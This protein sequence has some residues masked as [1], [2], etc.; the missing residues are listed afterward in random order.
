MRTLAL[1][2]FL[3]S[4]ASRVAAVCLLLL[5]ALPFTAPFS[6]CDLN[7]AL[8][9]TGLDEGSA[10]S[11]SNKIASDTALPIFGAQPLIVLFGRVDLRITRAHAISEI[12]Q[13]SPR[14]L[15]L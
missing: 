1:R 3:A 2:H 4:R 6:T 5:I 11:L 14:P 13:A 10:E 9:Q 8:L 12:P 15:R 7:D